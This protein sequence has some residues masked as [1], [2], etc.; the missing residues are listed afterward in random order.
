MLSVFFRN[1]ICVRICVRQIA[2]YSCMHTP[3]F[4]TEPLLIFRYPAA[5]SLPSISLSHD[6]L[7]T[8]DYFCRPSGGQRPECG[9]TS[10]EVGQPMFPCARADSAE[11]CINRVHVWAACCAENCTKPD[12]SVF[13]LPAYCIGKTHLTNH[14]HEQQPILLT[15][16]KLRSTR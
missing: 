2:H 13:T 11:I 8:C 14:R 7:L 1:C 10:D 6:L 5:Y 3:L 4:L 12:P 16:V 9:T 15:S